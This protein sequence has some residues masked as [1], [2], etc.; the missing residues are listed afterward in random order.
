MKEIKS[1][2]KSVYGL[3][4]TPSKWIDEAKYQNVLVITTSYG[5]S[6]IGDQSRKEYVKPV[7]EIKPNTLMKFETIDDEEIIINTAFIVF[8]EKRTVVS[9]MVQN[10][11]NHHIKSTYRTYRWLL[12]RDSIIDFEDRYDDK[13]D[14][15]RYS[16]V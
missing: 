7:K 13:T 15:Y 1:S 9:R 5:S 14:E 2:V 3:P 10:L 6:G 16:E 4:F 12:K 8:V 11:G